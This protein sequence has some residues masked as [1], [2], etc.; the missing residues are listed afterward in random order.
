MPRNILILCMLLCSPYAAFSKCAP[1]TIQFYL[2]KGFNQEQITELCSSSTSTP[3]TYEPFQ[4]PV[5]IYREGSQGKPG[6]TAEERKAI[7]VVQISLA[8]RSIEV[9]DSHINYIRPVCLRAGQSKEIDQ[10]AT[11]CLDLA[12]S[13][14]RQDLQV[15]SSGQKLLIF[16]GK[17]VTLSSSEIKRKHLTQDPFAQFSPD[18]R[19]LFKKNFDK[20]ESGNETAIPLVHG[21]SL[22]ETAN[23]LKVLSA[24]TAAVADNKSEVE[25]VFDDSYVPPSEEEYLA[26]KP[27]AI[28]EPKEKKK[29]WWNP[30]D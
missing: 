14:S 24:A 9:T 18:I 21:A 19:W 7:N 1:E 4:K 20:Q 13:I 22:P 26:S 29:K 27:E 2:D 15:H 17:Q 12:Y 23:A 11:K 6:I 28:K 10:R 25:R 16:G 30:F 5:V 8:A 3:Q